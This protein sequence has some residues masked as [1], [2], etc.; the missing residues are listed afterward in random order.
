MNRAWLFLPL[1]ACTV[2]LVGYPRDG[3][4]G[5]LEDANAPID[6]SVP[7]LPDR[8]E[9][10]MPDA[11]KDGAMDAGSM[12]CV[13]IDGGFLSTTGVCYFVLP[14]FSYPIDAGAASCSEKG[15]ALARNVNDVIV[16]AGALNISPDRHWVHSAKFGAD[17]SCD[18]ADA[19]CCIVSKSSAG[20]GYDVSTQCGL[21]S[22]TICE[23][24]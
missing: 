10:E 17:A 11:G 18:T 12:G 23:R 22:K 1:T 8:I 24:K 9:P 3:G 5:P 19:G 7:P 4:V 2:T 21:N 6:R 14:E 13:G 16:G 15:A 20:A